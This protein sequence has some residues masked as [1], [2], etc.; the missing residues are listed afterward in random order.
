MKLLLSSPGRVELESRAGST[1]RVIAVYVRSGGRKDA[2]DTR[3]T[4]LIRDVCDAETGALLT[5]HLWF[6]R[7]SI[8][9][10][11]ELIPGD[12]IVFEA[13]PIEYRTGYWGPNRVRKVL[14]PA[15]RDFRLTPPEGLRVIA[16]AQFGRPEAA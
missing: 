9:R 4:V 7:G 3:G 5:D 14:E 8:W 1:I 10:N 15:R 6:N 16:R 2:R 12:V 13:R 11:A